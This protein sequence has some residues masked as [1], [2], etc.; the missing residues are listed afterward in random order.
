MPYNLT[1]TIQVFDRHTRLDASQ[2]YAKIDHGSSAKKNLSVAADTAID[3]LTQP[4]HSAF[5]SKSAFGGEILPGFGNRVADIMMATVLIPL[6][7]V[8]AGKDVADGSLHGIAHLLQKN[9]T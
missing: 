4:F 6:G 5:G 2:E 3:V 9:N 8:F 7:I 1:N